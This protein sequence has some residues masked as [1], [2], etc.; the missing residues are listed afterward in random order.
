M[1]SNKRKAKL[2][3][4]R[5][6][7]LQTG[8]A[9]IAGLGVAG[10][11]FAGRPSE[12]LALTGGS[13]TV[14]YPED[15]HT[16]VSRWPRYG[17]QEKQAV[18][19]LLDSNKFYEELPFFEREWREYHHVPYVKAHINGTSALTSMFFALDLPPGSEI[20]VPSYTFFATILP[21][22]FFQYV[23]IFIDLDP[24]TACF[25]LDYA[26]KHLTKNTR[27]MI[28]MHS[29]GMPCDM[30]RISA[31]GKEHG[32]IVME[33]AAHAHGASLQG[34]KMGAWGAM[35]IFSFQAGKPLP[36]IEGGMGMYQTQEC[37]ER[38]AAFGHYEDPPKFPKDSPIRQY[39]GTGF[40]QKYRMHPLTAAILRQQLKSLDQRNALVRAQVRK[41]NDRLAQL[42][43][44]SEPYIRPDAQRV[45]YAINQLF[46]DETKAGFSR[47]ALVKALRAEGV[48]ASSADYPEQHKYKIYS[49]AKWWHHPPQVP[50]VL[51][52]TAQVNRTSVS[53]PLFYEE[54]PGLIDQY[55]MAFEKIWVHRGEL[56][57]V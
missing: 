12:T 6:S 32:L 44:L 43:G 18:C 7:F 11:G 35:A 42:P 16:A 34:K 46:L 17:P 4:S 28:P 8:T 48:W 38:A 5:R 54:V 45:Y 39:E 14:T 19:D 1:T 29:W 51:P 13:K 47:A 40:G 22:R 56:A 53:L 57:K 33:D 20:M 25:D 21:M 55:A 36:G 15:Q 2:G 27:A 37:Y 3:I 41:L 52:G 50:K 30:D 31:F 24:R 9:A 49:E 26:A 10:V 23:P